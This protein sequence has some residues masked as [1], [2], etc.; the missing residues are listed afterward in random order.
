MTKHLS[1]VQRASIGKTTLKRVE[2]NAINSNSIA[3]AD[4]M[5]NERHHRQPDVTHVAQH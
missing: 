5:M 1:A 2:P 4:L 3:F